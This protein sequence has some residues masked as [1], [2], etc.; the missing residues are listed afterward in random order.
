MCDALVEVVQG[1]FDVDLKGRVKRQSE[2]W[3]GEGYMWL[4]CVCWTWVL[5]NV[6]RI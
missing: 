6:S 3:M 2:A 1:R 5:C 4:F